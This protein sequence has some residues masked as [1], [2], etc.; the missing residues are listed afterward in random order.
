MRTLTAREAELLQIAAGPAR[1]GACGVRLDG[2]WENYGSFPVSDQFEGWHQEPG[3][4]AKLPDTCR[5]CYEVLVKATT[6]A[7]NAIVREHKGVRDKLRS[8]LHAQRE[9]ESDFKRAEDEFR[10]NYRRKP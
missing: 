6:D 7:A 9:R 8:E 4:P 10:A 3:K 5:D 1:V 2:G